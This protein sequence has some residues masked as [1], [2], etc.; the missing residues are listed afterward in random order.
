MNFEGIYFPSFAMYRKTGWEAVGGYNTD[1]KIGGE[2]WEYWISLIELGGVP[3]R[4]DET[5]LYYRRHS[6]SKTAHD[7]EK[8]HW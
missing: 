8:S 3:Y 4:L 2:D 7:Y 6:M 5:L 1:M